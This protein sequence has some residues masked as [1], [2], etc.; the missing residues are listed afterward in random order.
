MSEELFRKIIK[1]ITYLHMDKREIVF[2]E[3]IIL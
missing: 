3:G 1:N 2:N